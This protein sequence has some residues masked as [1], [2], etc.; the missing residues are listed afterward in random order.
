MK[1]VKLTSLLLTLIFSFSSLAYAVDDEDADVLAESLKI[2]ANH[3]I[4][5]LKGFRSEIDDNKIYENERE[6]GLS[7][8]LEDQERWDL[9]RERGLREYRQTKREESVNERGPEYQ[10]YLKEKYLQDKDYEKS[11]ELQVSIRNKVQGQSASLVYKL[12]SEEQQLYSARPRYT[13]RDRT[14]NKWVSGA[15]GRGGF[16]GGSGGFS[17]GGDF[18]AN[19]AP[20]AT[21]FPAVT[22]FPPAPAPYEGYEDFPIPPVYDGNNN[23]GVPTPY[24]PSFGADAGGIAVPPPPP[25]PPDFDF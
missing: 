17:A 3:N 9:L 8:F 10:D 11:R 1:L 23:G 7:E 2:E 22:D 21:D 14:H 5:R 16:S 19:P 12:E 25:P 15:G 13:L 18:P 24:D 6:K 20:P 4:N